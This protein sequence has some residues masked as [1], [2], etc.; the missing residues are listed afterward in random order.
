MSHL[1][2]FVR[3][4]GR[5]ANHPHS[6]ASKP[7]SRLPVTFN[8]V[9][10]GLV[11]GQ[12]VDCFDDHK[13]FLVMHFDGRGIFI[14][15]VEAIRIIFIQYLFEFKAEEIERDQ[16]QQLLPLA[17]SPSQPFL[18]RHATLLPNKGVREEPCVTR[19]K[20]LQGRGRLP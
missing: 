4:E 12:I 17:K 10:L 18:S 7:G 14:E 3:H 2:H 13:I 15:K 11:P 1:L 20:R 6:P 8:S 16:N 19:Q 9:C 5:L